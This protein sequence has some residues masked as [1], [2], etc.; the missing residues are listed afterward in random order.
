MSYTPTQ[1]P[2]LNNRDNRP[3]MKTINVVFANLNRSNDAFKELLLARPRDSVII[4]CESPT[5]D[6]IPPNAPGYYLIYDESLINS[7]PPRI[8]AYISNSTVDLLE[9][10]SCSRDLITLNLRDGWTIK[11]AYTDPSSPI[12]PILLTPIDSRTIIIGDFNAKDELWYDTTPLD[13][14]HSLA[15]GKSLRTWARRCH[16]CERGPRLPTRHRTGEKPSKLD[17]IWTRQDSDPFIVG[18]YSALSHSDHMILHAKFRLMKP[19][20]TQLSPR[21]DY[22]N[23]PKE[24]ILKFFQ[25]STP[26]SNSEDLDNILLESLKLIPRLLRNPKKLLPPDLRQQRSSLRQLMRKR[27]G[28]NQYITARKEY[29][30]N[31]REFINSSI[32]E[33]LDSAKDPEF[34]DFT[35]RTPIA[36]PIPTLTLNGQI[37]TSHARKAKCI[38]DYHHAGTPIKLHSHRTPDIPA[39]NPHEITEAIA[40]APRRSASSPDAVSAALLRL[41]HIAHPLCIGR[42]YTDI[43]RSG[44]HPTNWKAAIVVPIPKANKPTYTHPKSWRSIHLLSV[45]SKTLERIVLRRLQQDDSTTSTSPCP[46]GPSQFGSR[47]DLGTSD[48][49][50]TYLRWRENAANL[51]HFT[52]IISADVEGG[53]DRVDLSQLN[54]TDLNSLYT[55]WIRH[56]AGN[57]T[58]KIRHSSRLDPTQYTVNN[59]IPQGSPLSPLLFGA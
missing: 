37:Y 17:L 18:D 10:F 27:W 5:T 42:I 30:E 36:K 33:S 48:A 47:I 43:L 15:R 7:P 44:I 22:K 1:N 29:R 39:V 45:V 34:F 24:K 51:G 55:P 26:P 54:L 49:M 31:L 3:S 21:P 53:F 4:T 38:A 25:E 28:S 58:I 14:G 57:R 59:G 56:W 19:P 11:A 16:T 41:F 40:K 35:R 9:K 20:I 2:T 13:N 32:E 50:Q 12:D 23:M 52:T 6:N 46:M 8:C